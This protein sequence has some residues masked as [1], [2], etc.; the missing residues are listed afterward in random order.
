MASF[1]H[2]V[3]FDRSLEDRDSLESERR[4]PGLDRAFE[5][6][7]NWRPD[8]DAKTLAGLVQTIEGEIIPRLMLAHKTAYAEA[9]SKSGPGLHPSSEQIEEFAHLVMAH[10]ADLAWSYV[11]TLRSEGVGLESI[12][13]NLLAPTARHLGM[14]WEQDLCDFTDVT[15]ALGR[16]HQLLHGISGRPGQAV[17]EPGPCALLAPF[18]GE[19]HSFGVAMVSEL[20]RQAGWDICNSGMASK[21]ELLTLVRGRAFD[22]VGLSVA[23]D[24]SFDHVA[25]TIRALRRASR[26]RSVGIMVGGRLFFEQPELARRVGADAS[27]DD[28]RQALL[29]AESLLELV[30]KR[31]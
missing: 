3:S 30:A 22:I 29:Q 13:L 9:E 26:N 28:G 25:S 23:C 27:A 24:A 21:D 15:I 2:Q 11:E 17:A 16:L 31:C 20:F 19:Q 7:S 5:G 18:P 14:M 6:R 8:Q 1:V 12:C 10:N 4:S